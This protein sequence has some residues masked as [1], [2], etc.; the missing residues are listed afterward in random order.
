M[1]NASTS[2]LLQRVLAHVHEQR[3]SQRVR[4]VLHGLLGRLDTVALPAERDRLDAIVV[5]ERV[6][7]AE[8]AETARRLPP[9]A[10]TMTLSFSLSAVVAPARALLSVDRLG[11]EVEG[12]RVGAR[13]GEMEPLV[14]E[15]RVDVAPAV[16][17]GATVPDCARAVRSTGSSAQV[18][19]RLAIT[20][21]PS[22]AT[23]SSRNSI[24]SFA[25]AATSSSSIGREAFVISIS[26][27]QNF[28]K[29]PPVPDAPTVIRTPGLCRAEALGG[30]GGERLQRARSV[31]PDRA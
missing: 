28:S 18:L 22:F 12:A 21:M 7:Q 15:A 11:E 8:V 17:L 31:D 14:G 27:A 13:A 6:G 25:H 19:S 1:R 2:I 5:L 24:R 30:S 20:A 3:A 23:W 10:S 16:D 26:P 4:L 29:P 9:T